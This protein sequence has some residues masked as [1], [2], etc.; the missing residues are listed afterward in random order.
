MKEQKLAEYKERKTMANYSTQSH[1]VDKLVEAWCK[2]SLEFKPF[3]ADKKGNYGP[4]VSI[5]SMRAATKESL[6]KH[7]IQLTQGTILIEGCVFLVTKIA[8]GNQWQETMM[9]IKEPQSTKLSLDQAYGSSFS[10]Q[11]RY[12]LY[13][14]FGIKG[15]DLDP[16]DIYEPESNDDASADKFKLISDKQLKYLKSLLANFPDVE[17]KILATGVS[18]QDLKEDVASAYISKLKAMSEGAQ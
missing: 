4:Y 13:G 12:A 7:G 9:P 8:H 5:D 1:D 17:K 6:C 18:L 16:D 2:A 3:V 11:R 14:L 10:Y 15:E